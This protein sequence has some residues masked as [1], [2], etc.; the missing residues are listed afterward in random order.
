MKVITLCFWRR[1]QYAEHVLNSLKACAGIKDYHLVIHLDGP[2]MT[3][4]KK[5]CENIRMAPREIIQSKKNIGCNQSTRTVLERGFQHSDYV[6][7]VEEDVILAPD[8]LLYFEW[9]RQF[10]SD[11]N[12]FTIGAWRHRSGWLEGD[13]PFPVDQKIQ[14]KVVRS[15]FFH[16]WGWATWKDRWADMKAHWT[17]KDDLTLSWDTALTQHRHKTGRHELLPLVSRALNIGAEKGV[18]RGDSWLSYWAGS[19]GFKRDTN[20]QLVEER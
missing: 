16:C 14:T 20:Y 6:I 18:H 2:Q 13:G 12:L 1:P 10:G 19:T 9:A 4:M 15:P 11:K 5:L 3:S 8:A 7:H 17:T